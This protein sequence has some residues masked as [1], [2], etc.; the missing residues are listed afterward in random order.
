MLAILQPIVFDHLA[1]NLYDFGKGILQANIRKR[2]DGQRIKR[3]L[4]GLSDYLSYKTPTHGTKVAVYLHMAYCNFPNILD[5][6]DAV[7]ILK[8]EQ[9]GFTIL[10]GVQKLKMAWQTV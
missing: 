3:N 10:I 9:N 6:N 5:A 8:L 2:P 4:N 1:G 7:I